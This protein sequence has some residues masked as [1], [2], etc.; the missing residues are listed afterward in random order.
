MVTGIALGME[1]E[2]ACGKEVPDELIQ[3]VKTSLMGPFAGIGDSL[4]IG[5]LIPILLSI[6]LGWWE[7]MAV[8]Q[9]RCFMPQRGW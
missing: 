4:F 8:L 2:R 3:S 6:G 1:E 5:T 9:G 7:R